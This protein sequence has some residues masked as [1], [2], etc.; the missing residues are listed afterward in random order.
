MESEEVTILSLNKFLAFLGSLAKGLILGYYQKKW[1]KK[2]LL[3]R[4]GIP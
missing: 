2:F 4:E 1:K 3:L